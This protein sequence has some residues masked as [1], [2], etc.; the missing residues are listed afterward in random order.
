MQIRRWSQGEGYGHVVAVDG[1]R[2][3]AESHEQFDL[4]AKMLK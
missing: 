2:R 3:R 4:W 1:T